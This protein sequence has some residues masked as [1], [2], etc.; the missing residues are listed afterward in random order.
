MDLRAVVE[1]P[2]CGHGNV[3]GARFCNSCGGALAEQLS[4]GARKTVTVVFCDLVGS[5]RL[6]EGMDPEVLRELLVRYHAALRRVIERHGGT[7]EKF[8]GDAAMAVFGTP[9]VREDDALRAVRAA[10]EMRNGVQ[11]QG[12]E[13]KIGINTGQV[14]AGAG[15]T[16][17]TGDA[18]N[19]AARLE[20]AAQAGE[21]LM[22]HT[23]AQLVEQTVRVGPV[24]P[25]SLKGKSEPVSAFRL[26]ELMTEPPVQRRLDTPLVGR[27]R[28]LTALQAALTAAVDAGTPQ[29]A[30][31]AGPAGIGKSRLA[32]ELLAISPAR[33]L[34]ARCLSYGEGITYWPLAE[35]MAQIDDLDGV[36]AH[37]DADPSQVRARLTAAVEAAETAV[38]PQ[39]IAWGFRKLFESLGREQP[40]IVVFDDIHW[41]EPPLLDL[42]ESIAALAMDA[43]LLLLCTARPEL[44]ELRPSWSA[45]SPSRTLITLEP[46]SGEEAEQLVEEL[47]QADEATKRRIIETAEGNPLFVE[48]L[49][50]FQAEAS[51]DLQI[52]ATLQAVLMARIDRLA[53]EE[54]ALVACGSV[55]GRLFHRGAVRELLPDPARP[56]VEPTLLALVRK[57]LIRPSTATVPGDDGFRFRHILIRDAAYDA[58][59]KRRR[60]DLHEGYAQWLIDRLGRDAPPEILGYHLEQAYRYRSELGEVDP[61]L[62]QRAADVLLDA[63]GR[64][65]SRVDI[66]ATINL[67]GRA[68]EL[69]AD[70]DFRRQ[71]R[72]TLGATLY[73]AGEFA[74][75]QDALDRAVDEAR[76]AG[77]A[78]S[79]WL[80]RLHLVMLRIRREPEGAAE[81][82]TSEAQGAMAALG[83]EKDH[84][85]LGHAWRVLAEAHL[86]RSQA[87]DQAKALDQAREHAQEAGDRLLEVDSII[88]SVPPILFGPVSVQ[89]GLRLAE[90][91]CQRLGDAPIGQGFSLHVQG[92]MKAR[93]GEFDGALEAITQWR[94]RFRELGQEFLYA[95]TSACVWD[96]C[97]WAGEWE[98]GERA[99]REGYAFLEQAGEKAFLST[100]AAQMA[101]V[102]CR[103]GRLGEAQ[104]YTEISERLGASD[105]QLNEAAWRTVRA[106]ILARRGEH[107]RAD[108]LAREAIQ[109]ADGTDYLEL[110][111]RTWLVLAEVRRQAGS[112]AHEAAERAL[113]LYERKGNLVGVERAKALN[114]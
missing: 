38:S 114:A 70:A 77:D 83:P 67:L 4:V 8:V 44:L 76:A 104:K 33:V 107:E 112:D 75:A 32:Q 9:L 2:Q 40:T 63:A 105:D 25:L 58:I 13:V 71:L 111:A 68:L 53:D 74:G 11:A 113:A 101:E 106:E 85:V 45:A 20:Q 6:G 52:P 47:G 78:H 56:K 5:T 12:L 34:V 66:A 110:R 95:N 26:L 22:G 54:R 57:E 21:I 92:H 39:E 23:T 17:I 88:A 109:L 29:L 36:L 42:I 108:A 30:T 1:C 51:G 72:V 90:E 55:E 27:D 35:V 28:E 81:L 43:A 15:E 84:E 41:A 61:T 48:Q 94:D 16:L 96:V 3:A 80:A 60:A 49:M 100:V 103:Q 79:E 99:L 73:V 87:M 91:V 50:A 59:P 65:R 14:M 86:L 19:V 69:A 93:L 64:A 97:S 98:I 10:V 46:M 102:L 24:A 7:V 37:G 18:V 89:D 82:A 31:I 62:G